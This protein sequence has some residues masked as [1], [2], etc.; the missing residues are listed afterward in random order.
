MEDWNSF[1]KHNECKFYQKLPDVTDAVRNMFLSATGRCELM[2]RL[3][4]LIRAKPEIVNQKYRMFDGSERS[5][6]DLMCDDGQLQRFETYK[7]MHVIPLKLIDPDLFGRECDLIQ[8]TELFHKIR[9]NDNLITDEGATTPVGL[10]LSIP[11]SSL[12]HSCRPNT[13]PVFKGKVVESRVMRDIAAGEEV[14]ISYTIEDKPKPE[15]HQLLARREF[16]CK[17]DRCEAGDTPD[18][19]EAMK[20]IETM[21]EFRCNSEAGDPSLRLNQMMDELLIREKYQGPFHFRLTE[22]MLFVVYK[23]MFHET[24]ISEKEKQN[25]RILMEKLMKAFP[26]THG[27]D[28]PHFSFLS[29][30]SQRMKSL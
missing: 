23:R 17:C 8:L 12:N 26:I 10:G 1:H 7:D 5:F 15:R 6:A 28:H 2:L 9:I 29:F 18:E 20:M 24:P 25:M 4:L 22:D 14:T 13:Y 19:L 11:L 16:I 21:D 3:F 27:T 30:L